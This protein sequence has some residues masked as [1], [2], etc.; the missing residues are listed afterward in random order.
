MYE[1]IKR[2][3]P[4]NS[5][6]CRLSSFCELITLSWLRSSRVLS[7]VTYNQV[8]IFIEI[9]PLC[10][11]C[12]LAEEFFKGLLYV[13]VFKTVNKGVQHGCDHCIHHW[14]YG[15]CPGVLWTSRTEVDPKACAVEQGDNWKVRPTCGK[16]SILASSWW[17]SQNGG[18]NLRVREEN[19]S[20]R[21]NTNKS[22]SKIHNYIIEKGVRTSKLDQL[23]KFTEKVR[24]FQIITKR[25][26]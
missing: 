14:G 23:I 3:N 16:C 2:L 12:F 1:K 24:D 10:T 26:P 21:N 7:V 13:F 11:E 19:S 15:T 4:W 20:K 8:S 18:Y 5:I 17:N 22:S 6:N 25:E 9:I